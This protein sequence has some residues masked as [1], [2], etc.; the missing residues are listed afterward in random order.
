MYRDLANFSRG[1]ERHYELEFEEPALAT[2]GF[3]Y[4]R[5]GPQR[6][7]PDEDS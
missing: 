6:R 2:L 4:R 3:A 1:S 7:A 5:F